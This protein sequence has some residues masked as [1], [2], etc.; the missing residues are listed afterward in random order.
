M[1]VSHDSLDDRHHELNSIIRSLFPHLIFP[2]ILC[3]FEGEESRRTWKNPTWMMVCLVYHFFLS[4]F[5]V[6]LAFF[7]WESLA[8]IGYELF[9]LSEYLAGATDSSYYIPRVSLVFQPELPV[10][11][12]VQFFLS[13][14]SS[15]QRLCRCW[16]CYLLSLNHPLDV[17]LSILLI[18][19]EKDT[20]VFLR[21]R[22]NLDGGGSR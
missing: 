5:I 6:S 13:L 3:L 17:V 2:S 16:A 14:N 1:N 11:W 12:M 7:V 8:C 18:N 15:I 9:V 10:D 4:H 21:K 20:P 19:R 22:E